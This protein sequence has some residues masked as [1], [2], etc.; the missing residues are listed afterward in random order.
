ME[1]SKFSVITDLQYIISLGKQEL[2][3]DDIFSFSRPRVGGS[4]LA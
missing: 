3:I 1:G 2:V 4:R